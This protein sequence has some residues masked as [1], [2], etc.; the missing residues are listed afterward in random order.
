MTEIKLS[1]KF[2]LKF[3]NVF[4]IEITD[5]TIRIDT[6]PLPLHNRRVL[7]S[8]FSKELANL[9]KFKLFAG[10]ISK[11]CSGVKSGELLKCLVTLNC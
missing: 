3:F 7:Y 5:I 6:G 2:K 11:T 4:L 1:P 9:N 10:F 8:V